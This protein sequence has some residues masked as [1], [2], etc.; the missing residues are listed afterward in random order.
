MLDTKLQSEEFRFY[1]LF[2][3]G[4]TFL[5][6]MLMPFSYGDLAVW[7]AEGRQIF[8]QKTIY[9]NEAYSFNQTTM[10]P[11][12]WLSSVFY[13]ALDASYS[14]DA[15]FFLHRLIPVF[16]VGFW[17]TKYPLLLQKKNWPILVVCI[18]GLSM[19]IV[20]RPA[21]LTLPVI[22]ISYYLIE[23]KKVFLYKSRVFFL[24]VLW[25][26][27]HGSF[28]V[29]F[30]LLGFK[31]VAD[32]LENPRKFKFLERTSFVLMC[33]LA[34]CINPWGVKIY[35]YLWQTMTVSK[36]RMAEWQSLSFENS[37]AIFEA[38]FF[39]ISVA[40]LLG[41]CVQRKKMKQLFTSPILPL[42]AAAVMAV[43]NLPFY[44]MTL[45]LFWGK[46]LAA[47]EG[48]WDYKRPQLIQVV[49]NRS[50]ITLVFAAGLFMF[51]NYSQHIRLFLPAKY[52]QAYDYTSCFKIADY[53]NSRSTGKKI[54]NSW[55]VGAFLLYSQ[56]NQIFI[57]ARNIIY[58]DS[59]FNEYQQIIG[60]YHN[61]AESLLDKHQ[62]DYAVIETTQG[63]TRALKASQNWTF[64]ME[65]NG[66][67]LFERK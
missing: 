40:Y 12:P 35:H 7:I 34:T 17:L 36:V 50:I 41:V 24:I 53:I 28:L 1:F 13:Y 8:L 62:S 16:I 3:L 18:S 23:T 9:I 29:F 38:G 30:L 66:Y 43:R 31:Y 49:F 63:A 54:F 25:T 57:D 19:L 51:S 10:T 26:N 27:L 11:Y 56:K 60:N 46:S 14:I 58:S 52:Q 59:E 65:D 37:D 39:M 15:I 42:L 2:Y 5:F 67:S 33:L 21:L 44:Y 32:L 6:A 45:P 22:L 20:D 4:L 55:D 47:A 64:I 48:E 61:A